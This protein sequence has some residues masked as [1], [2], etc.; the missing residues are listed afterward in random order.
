MTLRESTIDEALPAMQALAS[1]IWTPSSRHHPGQL[2]WS[3]RY[4]LPEDL[5]HGP[6]A[7]FHSGPHLV[8]WAW[9]EA[10]DWLELCADPAHPE[11]V[12]DAAAW[13]LGRGA[14]ETVRTMALETEQHVLDGLAAAGFEVEDQ[15]WFTHHHLDLAELGEVGGGGRRLPLPPRR[16]G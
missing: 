1:R 11:V 7:L 10:D 9:A 8:G 13:F 6:V 16:A 3:A 5:G 4:A 2:A 15:P 12:G 14:G